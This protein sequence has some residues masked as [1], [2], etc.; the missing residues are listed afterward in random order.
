MPAIE[1]TSS[2]C[3]QS[4]RM[5]QWP[6]SR[7]SCITANQAARVNPNQESIPNSIPIARPRKQLKANPNRLSA[8]N[9]TVRTKRNTASARIACGSTMNSRWNR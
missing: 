9:M 3:D 6:Q 4:S 1:A 8:D 5:A 2:D 7:M